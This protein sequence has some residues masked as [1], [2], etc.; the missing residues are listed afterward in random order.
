MTVL[1]TGSWLSKTTITIGAVPV[2]TVLDLVGQSTTKGKIQG[3]SR[4]MSV[5]TRKP[6]IS[7]VVDEELLEYLE[8]WAR[9]EE[10][11]VSNLVL[12]LLRDAT[13]KR[14]SKG[15]SHENP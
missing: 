14:K 7:V 9:S 12:K 11:S 1:W 3:K 13:E 8:S 6:R 4:L 15:E 10:R 2:N 5:P